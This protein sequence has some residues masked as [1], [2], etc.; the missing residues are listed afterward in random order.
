MRTYDDRSAAVRENSFC[1]YRFSSKDT[2]AGTPK[3]EINTTKVME[4]H[5]NEERGE[6]RTIGLGWVSRDNMSGMV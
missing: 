1:V 4:C 5:A 6:E 2:Q 3:I